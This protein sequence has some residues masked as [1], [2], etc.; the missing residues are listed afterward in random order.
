VNAAHQPLLLQF[1]QITPR[2]GFRGSENSAE[3]LEID[4][5]LTCE[6]FLNLQNPFGLA[7]VI[8][9]TRD[10]S[11]SLRVSTDKEVVMMNDFGLS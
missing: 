10:I 8:P 7:H 11:R 6:E 3:L 2:T 9:L 1:E 4:E 5:L